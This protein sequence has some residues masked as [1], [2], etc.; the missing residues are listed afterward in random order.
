MGSRAREGHGLNMLY[1]R[2]LV[3]E[4]FGPYRGK[5]TIEFQREKGVYIVSGQNGRGKTKLHNAFRWALYGKILSRSG[6]QGAS[7]LVNSE[8][9]IESGGVGSFSTILDF[10]HA[11]VDYRLTRRYDERNQP[12]VSVLLERNNV[13]LNQVDTDRLL[14]QIAPDSVSQFFLFDGELLRQYESLLD[15]DSDQGKKL[16]EDIERVLGIP[17][18]ANALADAEE[19]RAQ[20]SRKIAVQASANA[21]TQHLGTALREAGDIRA[22]LVRDRADTKKSLQQTEARIAE[23]EEAL[24]AQP[25]AE[26]LIGQASQLRQQKSDLEAQEGSTRQ[27]LADLSGELWMA[28]L[29]EPAQERLGAVQAETDRIAL[30]RHEASA[31][32][33]D[34]EYLEHHIECPV[35]ERRLDEGER[36]AI[37]DRVAP[38]ATADHREQLESDWARLRRNSAALM[39]IARYDGRLVRDRDQALRRVRLE[40][41]NVAE[42]ISLLDDQLR[43][44]NQ[45]EI[46]SL[47]RER[48][49]RNIELARHQKRIG[50]ISDMILKQD[51]RINDLN[52]N[53]ARLNFKPDPAVKLKQRVTND[54][55]GLFQQSITV[56][57]RQLRDR[58][59]SAA[60]EIFT[61]LS[62]EADYA[63]LKITDRYGLEIIDKN[64]DVVT[65]RSAGYEHLVALSLISALQGSAAVRGTVV[66]DSPFGRLDEGHT[67]RVVAALPLMADQVILLAF[68][69][70]FD[71]M[72]ALRALG[73]DLVAEFELER[74]S[75][76][77][78]KIKLREDI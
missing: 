40:L 17:I 12:N 70:E 34:R 64:G 11:R 57:R 47:S 53:L 54:L 67:D 28:V 38:R 20:A 2:R 55:I 76:R 33:R 43:E 35:C 65:G 73:S 8:A 31:A 59:E 24:S 14:Q 58:V 75:H 10:V 3:I 78:T 49:E 39:N 5:Q 1:F 22:Q 37:L 69:S 61:Q 6:A 52:D 25:R 15:K 66:M 63:R 50:E 19:A 21:N 41:N 7:E 72:A 16:E 36:T 32:I 9:R 48:D 44:V 74:I 45:E 30:Q 68:D 42:E 71:R 23:I 56:Y 46:R 77:N 29:A 60:S 62:A 26:R 51:G 18:V 13:P 27:A 4:D